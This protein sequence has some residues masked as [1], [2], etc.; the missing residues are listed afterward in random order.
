MRLFSLSP[1]VSLLLFLPVCVCYFES[2]W[3]G[4]CLFDTC[5][6]ALALASMHSGIDTKTPVCFTPTRSLTSHLPLTQAAKASGVSVYSVQM[7]FSCKIKMRC[8]QAN[9][10]ITRA[11][12]LWPALW[13]LCHQMLLLP[14]IKVMKCNILNWY[15]HRAKSSLPWRHWWHIMKSNKRDPL[16]CVASITQTTYGC[17]QERLWLLCLTA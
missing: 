7:W 12:N 9:A 17:P 15:N 4:E 11:T 5:W 10:G 8:R 16:P 6:H 14:S 2:L 1:V 13:S 3:G